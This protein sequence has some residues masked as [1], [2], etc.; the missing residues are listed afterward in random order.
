MDTGTNFAELA[1]PMSG[2]SAQSLISRD[3]V[4]AQTAEAEEGDDAAEEGHEYVRPENS[5]LGAPRERPSRVARNAA[6]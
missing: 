1:Q 5:S 3:L 6:E 4:R 2:R